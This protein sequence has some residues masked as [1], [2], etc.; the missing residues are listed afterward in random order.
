M[1]AHVD[2]MFPQDPI[3]DAGRHGRGA[4]VKATARAGP[5]A[6]VG[7]GHGRAE[8]AGEFSRRALVHAL[9]RHGEVEPF[10]DTLRDLKTNL[11]R[12]DGDADVL[13]VSPRTQLRRVVAATANTISRN[14]M[15]LAQ[16]QAKA[17]VYVG[18]FWVP[19]VLRPLAHA[20]GVRTTWGWVQ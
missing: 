6:M 16:A 15:K 17:I 1:E 2:V 7:K 3:A 11:A 12:R 10:E 14:L 5:R 20:F 18:R 8:E 4:S 9:Q 13:S 19:S